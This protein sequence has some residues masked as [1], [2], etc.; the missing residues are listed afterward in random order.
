MRALSVVFLV[1]VATLGRAQARMGACCDAANVSNV[2][3]N[4]TTW[5]LEAVRFEANSTN[6]A[7]C[8]TMFQCIPCGAE[9]VPKHCTYPGLVTSRLIVSSGSHIN[10]TSWRLRQCT[11]VVHA[12]TPEVT[13]CERPAVTAY[14]CLACWAT[15]APRAL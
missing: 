12:V 1:L 9:D 6:T 3:Q 14:A 2:R 15:F 10:L 13:R 4:A 5:G 8:P 11:S 7:P